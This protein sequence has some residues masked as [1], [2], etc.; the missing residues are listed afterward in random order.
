[1]FFKDQGEEHFQFCYKNV[2]FQEM[3]EGVDEYVKYEACFSKNRICL[4]YSSI[5]ERAATFCKYKIEKKINATLVGVLLKRL[6]FG[7]FYL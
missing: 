4:T 1:L 7:Q 6:R 3:Q 5:M 2:N